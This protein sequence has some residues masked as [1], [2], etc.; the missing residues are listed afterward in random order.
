MNRAGTIDEK[1]PRGRGPR[2]ARRRLSTGLVLAS[3]LLLSSC[4]DTAEADLCTQYDDVVAAADAVR[5]LDPTT[6]DA[7]AF[8]SSIQDLGTQLDELQATAEGR[9][10]KATSDL[11]DALAGLRQAAVEADAESLAAARPLLQDSLDKVT[12]AYARLRDV[13]RPECDNS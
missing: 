11:R 3:L 13:V 9:L 6:D 5:S 4:A 12:Q 10:D 2:L 8:R 1:L 7:E